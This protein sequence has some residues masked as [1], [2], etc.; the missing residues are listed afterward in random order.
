MKRGLII[1]INLLIMGFILLFIIRYANTTA[2]ESRKN[3]IIAFEKMTMTTN[4]IIVNYLEYEQHLCDIW[5]NYI[6]RSAENGSP[7]TAEEAISFIRKAK[8]SAEIEGQLIFLDSPG[9]EGISSTVSFPSI[10]NM[11]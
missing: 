2:E 8:I 5:A 1:I 3:E 11:G 4:E 10:T 6:N 7:M 9:R